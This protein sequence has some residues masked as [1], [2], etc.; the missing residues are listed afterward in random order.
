[1]LKKLLNKIRNHGKWFYFVTV[2]YIP[3]EYLINTDMPKDATDWD[4][5][6]LCKRSR[7][8]GFYKNFKTAERCV[9]ENWTNLY[10]NGYYNLILGPLDWT[11]Q[12]E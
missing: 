9:K 2:F 11:F 12:K 4:D 5:P 6:Y 8:W 10:E 1:M 3:L 7:C